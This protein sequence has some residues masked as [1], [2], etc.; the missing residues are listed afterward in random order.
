[1][2]VIRLFVSAVLLIGLAYPQPK[3]PP[4]YVGFDRNIYPGDAGMDELRRTFSFTGY[5]LNAPP[6]AASS[7]W[8]GKRK[9]LRDNGFGFL[10]LFNGRTYAQ[11]KKGDPRATGESDG[12]E[13]AR[14]AA[15]E[16]FP[17]KSIIF[18][19]Q[20]EG[21][22]L[23]P[24]QRS[25]LHAWVDAVNKAGY[26]AGVD[27]SGIASKEAGGAS[28]TTARDIREN[29]EGRKIEFFVA[30]DGCPP[31]P[32]CVLKAPRVETS[33]VEFAA[34]WQFA[35]SP[36]RKQYTASCARSYAKDGNCYAGSVFVD[37]DVATT[38]DPSRGR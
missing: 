15:G 25:Y 29:A 21:G 35:Q 1:M 10:V 14:L 13:A 22:R 9:I 27:C 8:V 17:A 24:E 6:G 2:F 3:I 31:A 38:A 28:V 4:S 26:G 32:G 33:G 30:N 23:L 12:K 37:L 20:E 7:N 19:D 34:V 16:G 18:L 36:R 11:L 5:W